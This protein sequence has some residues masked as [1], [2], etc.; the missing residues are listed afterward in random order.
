ML[1]REEHVIDEAS[2]ADSHLTSNQGAVTTR[3]QQIDH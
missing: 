2:L 3:D 1:A